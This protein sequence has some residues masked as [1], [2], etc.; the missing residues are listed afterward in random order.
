MFMATANDIKEA[1]R[2]GAIENMIETALRP[3]G[4]LD[5]LAA[6]QAKWGQQCMGCKEHIAD[7]DR[8]LDGLQTQVRDDR[9]ALDTEIDRRMKEAWI[10]IDGLRTAVESRFVEE[11]RTMLTIVGIAVTVGGIITGIVMHY[12]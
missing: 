1:K 9:L 2:Q 3:G 10:G 7:S 4:T 8:R 6:E 5:R 11:H 12:V